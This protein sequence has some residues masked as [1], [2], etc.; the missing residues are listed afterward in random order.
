MFFFEKKN[1]KTLT[2]WWV[3][4]LLG[5][6]APVCPPSLSVVQSPAAVPAG[7]T[8]YA[9]ADPPVK[10]PAPAAAMVLEDMLFSE[11]APDG[12]GWLAPDSADGALV[13]TWDFT[14][15]KD[16]WLSCAYESTNV[17]VSIRLPPGLATCTV[18]QAKDNTTPP[19]LTC[20]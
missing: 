17:I 6:A 20:R 9:A 8:A 19:T 10:M 16:V 13:S 3:G 14:G 1:Q 4:V 5:G 18:H 11:G 12:A 15:A 7:F 2:F